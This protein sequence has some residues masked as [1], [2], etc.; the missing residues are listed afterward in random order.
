MY[1]VLGLE[2]AAEESPVGDTLGFLKKIYGEF[3]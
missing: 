2:E 3:A 1:I